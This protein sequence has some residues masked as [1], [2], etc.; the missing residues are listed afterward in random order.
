MSSRETR[1]EIF[2]E[3]NKEIETVMSLLIEQEKFNLNLLHFALSDSFD[4][5]PLLSV[6]KEKY[7]HI[8]TVIK[9]LAMESKCR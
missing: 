8:C 1:S 5:G 6:R 2:L 4:V 3:D 7:S 9:L